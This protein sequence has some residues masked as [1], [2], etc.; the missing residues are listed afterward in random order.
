LKTLTE[1]GYLQQTPG[2]RKYRISLKIFCLSNARLRKLTLRQK[3]HG[4][5]QKL[6]AKTE[7]QVYLS[8]PFNGLSIVI[9]TFF[10]VAC[11]DDAGLAIGQVHPVNRSACGK[12]CAAYVQDDQIDAFLAGVDWSAR[13]THT[14]TSPEQFKLELAKVRREKIA[15]VAAETELGVGAVG[16]PIFNAAG[17]LA[18]A[19]GA[20]LPVRSSWPVELWDKFKTETRSIAASI[21]LAL[22]YEMKY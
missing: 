5:L 20:V 2:S 17:E 16:A 19:I 13:T 22:G 8:A 4:Y 14:I 18:G 1:S 9:D 10:P 21:S 7:T 3:A 12:V 6:A 15:T 11:A